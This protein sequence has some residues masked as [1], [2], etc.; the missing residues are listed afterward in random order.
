M[1]RLNPDSRIP[2][3]G[4]YDWLLILLL[5]LAAMLWINPQGKFPLN[6]DWGYAQVVVTLLETGTYQAGEWPVMTLFTQV[7][8][9]A[10][11]AKVFGFSFTVLRLST[12]VLATLGAFWLW[13]YCRQVSADRAWTWLAV[14]TLLFNPLYCSLSFTF[15]TDVPFAV[16]TLAAVLV[17]RHACIRSATWSFF[18]AILLVIAATLIRQPGL[19]L[20]LAFGLSW[21]I[22]RPRW[23]QVLVALF[24]IG[25]TYAALWWYIHYLST[26]ADTPGE[27]SSFWPM[28]RRLRPAFLWPQFWSRGGLI[29]FTIATML[30]PLL[31]WRFRWRVVHLSPLRDRLV[32]G[33]AFLMSIFFAWASWDAVPMGNIVYY[34]GIGPITLPGGFNLRYA[35]LT[36]LPAWAWMISK[37][38][39]YICVWLLLRLALVRLSSLR[40]IRPSAT[41]VWKLSLILFL[42]AYFV[43]LLVEFNRFDRYQLVLLPL[44]ILLLSGAQHLTAPTWARSM[45]LISLAVISGFSIAG[46]RDYLN[47]NR[48]RWNIL[49]EL[50]EER[51]ISPRQI[52]GGLEFNGWYN[53]GPQNP[54][55]RTGKSWWFVHKDE[56]ALSFTP[57]NDCYHILETHSIPGFWPG[58]DSLYLLH[59]PLAGSEDTLFTNMEPQRGDTIAVLDQHGIT[60]ATFIGHLSQQR[61][62][63]GRYALLLTQEQPY[64][65]KVVLEDVTPCEQ[66]TLTVWRW[67][68]PRS[69]GIV[70]AAPGVTDFHTFENVFVDR[71]QADGWH[72]LRH[73][74]SL[75]YNYPSDSLEIYLWQPNRDSVWMDDLRIIQRR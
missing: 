64:A 52:D 25:L 34:F 14:G 68:K 63:S 46:T 15:M 73:E 44:L 66:L 38:Y 67:G 1:E 58:G 72:R 29:L 43:Y 55:S 49:S 10:L 50:V 65:A 5:W 21:V 54:H 18:V 51:G 60:T 45:S 53:T 4:R 30:S 22:Y 57:Y 31:W 70:V 42:V 39:G 69:A 7:L 56:Y 40:S 20:S 36:L 71:S 6:D 62:H 17:Y 3:A 35:D 8:W 12:L 23:R 48:T 59:R 28:L 75:P 2:L 61:A 24:G 33:S 19:L 32:W 9:G 26:A 74:V 11:F 37:T 27:L 41:V 47:W 16:T 13:Q